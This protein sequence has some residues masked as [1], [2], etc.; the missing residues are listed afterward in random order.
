MQPLDLSH[1][2]FILFHAKQ[3]APKVVAWWAANHPQTDD[4]YMMNI[5]SE[6]PIV[7]KDYTEENSNVGSV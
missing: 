1:S 5:D 7:E 2:I 4:A 3:I 6:D